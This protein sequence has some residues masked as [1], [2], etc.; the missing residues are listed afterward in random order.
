MLKEAAFSGQTRDREHAH[1]TGDGV[2]PASVSFCT[3][4]VTLSSADGG[5][6]CPGTAPALADATTDATALATC[7]DAEAD[8]T[9]ADDAPAPAELSLAADER[10]GAAVPAAH[11]S[12]RCPRTQPGQVKS[13][14]YTSCTQKLTRARPISIAFHLKDTTTNEGKEFVR[15]RD[16]DET[17]MSTFIFLQALQASPRGSRSSTRARLRFRADL[18]SVAASIGS[19]SG[20]GAADCVTGICAAAETL[21]ELDG[22]EL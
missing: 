12:A 16:N 18:E 5:A 14:E 15:N 4:E 19:G 7:A 10:A 13:S 22:N 9:A 8:V 17:S 3:A 21:E 1:K 11:C 2:R 20:L 6:A